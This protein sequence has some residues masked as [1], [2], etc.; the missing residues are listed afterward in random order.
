MQEIFFE[1]P[2]VFTISLHESGKT[3]YPWGGFEDEIGSGTGLGYNVNVPLPA[4][5]YN[6]A[7]L[8]AFDAV[9]LPLIGAYRP[10]VIVP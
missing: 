1:R 9:V 6:E 5:T 3:L 7:Y 10:D 2:D 8:S 4:G